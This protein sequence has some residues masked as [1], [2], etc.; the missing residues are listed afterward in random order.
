MSAIRVGLLVGVLSFFLCSM[1][2]PT[3][4][5]EDP[6]YPGVL[7]LGSGQRWEFSDLMGVR[8]SKEGGGYENVEGKLVLIQDV[9]EEIPL[10][11]IA[12]IQWDDQAKTVTIRFHDGG[13]KKTSAVVAITIIRR[14]S[15]AMV[16]CGIQ[17]LKNAVVTF[18]K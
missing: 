3:E 9:P 4:A 6:T 12:R 15:G 13:E 17:V 1:P 16:E 8:E 10:G 2:Y 11:K 18:D 7:V 14:G 5:K